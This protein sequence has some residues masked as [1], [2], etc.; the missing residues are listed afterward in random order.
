[1][2]KIFGF[3]KIFFC[4]AQEFAQIWLRKLWKILIRHII[5][6]MYSKCLHSATFSKE[7][8]FFRLF[9]CIRGILKELTLKLR[10][11]LCRPHFPSV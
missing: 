11:L 6:S 9:I 7:L 8:F 5:H 2:A 3:K 4:Q 1:M 10:R